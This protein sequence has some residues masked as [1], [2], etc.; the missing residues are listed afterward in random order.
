MPMVPVLMATALTAMVPTPTTPSERGPLMP[1]LMLMP[2]M[3]PM[4]MAMLPPPMDTALMPMVPVLMATALTA[5][6][7]T[8]TTPSERGL[9]MPMLMLMPTMVP[10]AMA[11]L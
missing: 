8:P 7:P 10:M 1:M 11:M 3:V 4:A 5:M 9:L 2:T 6:V